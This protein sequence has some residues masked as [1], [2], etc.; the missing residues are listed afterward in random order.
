MRPVIFFMLA[1]AS[2]SLGQEIADNPL[3]IV[4][5]N[6][7]DFTP[8]IVTVQRKEIKDCPFWVAGKVAQINGGV[9]QV[10]HE[11]L[12]NELTQEFS[13]EM[14]LAEPATQLKM[15]YAAQL[16][17]RWR[18]GQLST[19]EFMSLD[20]ETR[21][22]IYDEIQREKEDYTEVAV[23]VKNLPP[24]FQVLGKSIGVFALPIAVRGKGPQSSGRWF[25]YGAP[26]SGDPNDFTNKYFVTV[27]GFV[28]QQMPGKSIQGNESV[29]SDTNEMSIKRCTHH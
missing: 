21:E 25:D 11:E 14:L 12:R 19:G 10:V 5:T 6:V 1:V 27:R 13:K 24:N 15:E 28:K 2:V 20:A 9:T 26:L 8:I 17:G 7:F 23:F 18:K 16:L 3:R 4:G 22:I 29:L